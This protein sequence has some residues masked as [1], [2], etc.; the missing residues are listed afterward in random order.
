MTPHWVAPTHMIGLPS[1]FKPLLNSSN[2]EAA[3]VL[4]VVFKSSRGVPLAE[5][6]NVVVR[7]LPSFTTLLT[8]PATCVLRNLSAG[9]RFTGADADVTA[10][11]RLCRDKSLP[12]WKVVVSVVPLS[13]SRV[14]PPPPRCRLGGRRS[15]GM[16]FTGSDAAPCSPFSAKPLRLLNSVSSVVPSSVMVVVPVPLGAVQACGRSPGGMMC[17]GSYAATMEGRDSGFAGN[18]T[19]LAKE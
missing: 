3:A 10:G 6:L 9:R 4:F 5:V 17:T 15:T 19:G 14:V 18:I 1:Q 7:V 13:V 12:T 11:L 8:P 2:P 16:M